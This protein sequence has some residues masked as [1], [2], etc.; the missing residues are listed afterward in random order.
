MASGQTGGASRYP[1]RPQK[2]ID[3][4]DGPVAVLAQELRDLRDACGCPPYRTLARQQYAGTAHQRLADAARGEALPPWAVVEAYVRGCRAY[5]LH[6]HKGEPPPD[7]AGDL[8]PWRELYRKASGE[9]PDLLSESADERTGSQ[10][11][12]SPGDR[13]RP[14]PSRTPPGGTPPWQPAA[15][16]TRR[17]ARST[18]MARATTG[19]WPKLAA[20]GVLALVVALAWPSSSPSR[21]VTVQGTARCAYVTALPAPVL[22]A[23]SADAA[24]VK[25]KHLGDGIE[26][27][28]LPHPSGWW[29][30]YTPSNRPGHN[31]MRTGVL[32]PGVAGT[33]PCP[34]KT[35]AL[36]TAYNSNSTQEQFAIGSDC[37]VYHRWQWQAGGRFS[38]WTNLGGCA[39]RQGLAVGMNGDG[40]LMAF[41]IWPDHTARY[42]SQSKPGLGPWTGWTRIGADVSTGL[43]VVSAT[44]GSSPVRIY[45]S[46]QSGNLWEDTQAQANCCWSGWR[47]VRKPMSSP[48]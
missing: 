7:S 27:L 3:P 43:S 5:H 12:P 31:W 36:V 8:A 42:K 6:K 15:T 45:A 14:V 23:P 22:A 47:K 19:T 11:K 41:V 37:R 20:L 9:I 44:S 30:V 26:I 18:V 24:P 1:G 48:N 2:R 38:P 46:D 35:V 33:R 13:A 28:P 39:S 21:P 32:S 29:P 4:R 25:S 16:G 17:K 40:E 34:D 10:V